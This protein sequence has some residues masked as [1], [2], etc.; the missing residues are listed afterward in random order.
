VLEGS[1]GLSQ[2]QLEHLSTIKQSGE[3][4]QG[5]INNLLDLTKLEAGSVELE[6]VDF[7][8]RDM[9]EGALDQ[10]APIAQ[11]KEIEVRHL[12]LR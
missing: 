11:K 4:L 9:I 7:R 2:V 12:H 8:L 3:A 6:H 1:S 5:I 10:I